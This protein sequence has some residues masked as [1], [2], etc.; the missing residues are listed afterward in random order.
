MAYE[1]KAAECP[2]CDAYRVQGHNYCRRCRFHLTR[3]FAQG[4]LIAAGWMA[5]EKYC[6]YC[7]AEHGKCD[8]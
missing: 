8:H 1:A 6:G 3:G 7:G 5:D 2:V 4:A